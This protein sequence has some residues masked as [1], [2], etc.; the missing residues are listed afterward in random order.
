[1]NSMYCA[2]CGKPIRFVQMQ[3]EKR[4][5]VDEQMAWV[6]PAEKGPIQAFTL[7]GRMF[8]AKPGRCGQPGAVK[9][10]RSHWPNCK[11]ASDPKPSRKISQAE[12]RKQRDEARP[13][14]ASTTHI[15]HTHL[16]PYKGEKAT[17]KESEQLALF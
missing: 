5:P 14:R 9:A 15:Y 4:M 12:W 16:D 7:G 13:C 3:N 11:R 6:I 10:W 1:M 17:P 8:R 2:K